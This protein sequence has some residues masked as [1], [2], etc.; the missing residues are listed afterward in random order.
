MTSNS[1]D[2]GN[3]FAELARVD[4]SR[5]VEKKG[6]FS[7]LSWPFAVTE[8]L[9]RHPQATWRVFEQPDGTPYFATP[10]G[11][12]V[13][14]G[15]TVAGVERV[16]IHPVLDQANRPIDNPDAFAINTSIQR[17]LVKGIA[18]HGLGLYIYAG[19][20]LPAADAPAAPARTQ[21]PRQRSDWVRRIAACRGVAALQGLW[22]E[23][24]RA[25]ELDEP[26]RAAF[27]ARAAALNTGGNGAPDAAA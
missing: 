2:P 5:H 1:T 13:K 9:T 7:Y 10:A 15:V 14:V 25:G 4:C 16:Q 22:S 12:F 26:L 8:L 20:D 18:L 19:E 24:Q 23:C 17:A 6:R 21:G 11:C 27:T 3:Y